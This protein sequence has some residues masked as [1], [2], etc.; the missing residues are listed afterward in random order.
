MSDKCKTQQKVFNI[1]T[2]MEYYWKIN[3]IS[4][5][6]RIINILTRIGGDLRVII[7]KDIVYVRAYKTLFPDCDIVTVSDK[8]CKT[9]QDVYSI[10]Y[11]Q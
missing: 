4:V 9:Q 1:G 3:E 5:E 2:N 11:E 6:T 7:M 10:V 8:L